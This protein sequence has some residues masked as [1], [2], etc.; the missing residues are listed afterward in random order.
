MSAIVSLPFRPFSAHEIEDVRRQL[1][2]RGAAIDPLD[3]VGRLV[4]TLDEVSGRLAVADRALHSVEEVGACCPG[5]G[6]S[7]FGD[8]DDD[9]AYVAW[10]TSLPSVPRG[11]AVI[12]SIRPRHRSPN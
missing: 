6:T 9:C 10:K 1:A 4:A 3:V 12:R 8:H 11:S 7:D 2:T 5:C